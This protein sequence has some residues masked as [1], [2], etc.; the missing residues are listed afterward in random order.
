MDWNSNIVWKWGAK[1]P[2]GK[3]R[4]NHDPARL[5]NGNM[6]AVVFLESEVP[7]VDGP[8]NDQAIYEIN[9][10]GEI[11]W[12]WIS[13]EHIEE[14]GLTGERRN[15]SSARNHVP[16]PAFSSSTTCSPLARTSD[17]ISSSYVYKRELEGE[18]GT[19]STL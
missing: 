17:T 5:A 12:R 13:S 16:G 4:Q 6:L 19:Y 3:A 11:V 1:A 10:E 2:E 15:C 7:G 9:P 14:L 8:V 18:F